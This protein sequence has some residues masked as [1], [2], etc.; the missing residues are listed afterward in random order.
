MTLYALDGTSPDIAPDTWVA[1]DAAVIGKVA[2]AAGASAWFGAVLRG[3][4][5]WISVGAGCAARG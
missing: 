4:N 3:D 2:L 5:E 1:P